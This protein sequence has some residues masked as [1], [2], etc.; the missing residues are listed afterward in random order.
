MRPRRTVRQGQRG[1]VLP[2]I[3][4]ALALLTGFAG[5]SVD[6]GHQFAQ[7]RAGQTAVDAAAV[8][9][10]N[11]LGVSSPGAISTLPNWNDV[12]IAAA[13][14]YVAANGFATTWPTT[15]TKCLPAATNSSS[16]FSEEF[17]D[18]TYYSSLPGACT[19]T[20]A[21]FTSEV[22]IN[23]P[24]LS[25]G[26]STMPNACS[27]SATPAGSPDN[28]VQVVLIQKVGNFIMQL[29]GQSSQYITTIATG[30]DNPLGNLPS[31]IAVQLYQATSTQASPACSG[32]GFQCFNENALALRTLL[33]CAGVLDNCP[34]L[35]A[36]GGGTSPGVKK[37]GTI[38][39]A[40]GSSVPPK[41]GHIAVAAVGGDIV[42]NDN[43]INFC[44]PDGFTCSNASTPNVGSLGFMLAAGSSL[45]CSSLTTNPGGLLGQ[46]CTSTGHSS[47]LLPQL[48]LGPVAGNP[49][50]YAAPAA[51]SPP[52]PTLPTNSCG[53]LILNGDAITA[54]N[55][56][57]VFF[58]TPAAGNAPVALTAAQIPA[59][60]VPPVSSQ[61]T[62]MPGKYSYIAINFG[63][64]QFQSGLFEI[65]GNAPVNLLSLSP[66]VEPNGID[67]SQEQGGN[68]YADWDLC[69][70]GLVTGC[71][72]TAGVWIGQGNFLWNHGS[73]GGTTNITG[74]GVSFHFDSGSGGFVSTS[75]VGS[76]SLAGPA[77]AAMAQIGGLPLLFDL[78]NAT[79]GVIHLDGPDGTR[80]SGLV[81]QARSASGGGGGVE[82]DAGL[83]GSHAATLAGQVIAY[84]LALFGAAAGIAVDFSGYWS[85][86][87][88]VTAQLVQ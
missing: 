27:A 17:F 21:N 9:G 25:Y 8:V 7:K 4:L 13:H 33:T 36:G 68:P 3:V 49:V 37:G 6:L 52:T 31:P 51:W 43:S 62:I 30:Y 38:V 23:V 56:P 79:A 34:T 1:Q 71:A 65:T 81:Y 70:T 10:A 80:F 48:L 59:S 50:T 77:L 55:S 61:Y 15:T 76:I 63:P 24:P 29:F 83:G 66:L 12:S 20:P 58:N 26:G 22:L 19:A 45:Y 39:G 11:Q 60:C 85:G 73:G 16:Q 74:T 28:C 42:N 46:T 35:F 14:D 67:H 44:D 47:P 82:I 32:A 2:I 18:A 75:E 78:E 40:D 87:P 5:L 72:Q 57:P 53:G 64:Y 54:A 41:T 84:R 88:T 69:T 86:T